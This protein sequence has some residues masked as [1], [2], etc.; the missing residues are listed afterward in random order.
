MSLFH[1]PERQKDPSVIQVE[2]FTCSLVR[3][4]LAV[5]PLVVLTISREMSRVETSMHRVGTNTISVLLAN[6]V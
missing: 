4:P 5:L 1:F 2:S 6:N 3:K